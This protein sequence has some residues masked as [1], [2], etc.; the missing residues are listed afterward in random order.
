[1]AAI[2][3]IAG[4]GIEEGVAAE[5]RSRVA[6]AERKQIWLIVWPGVSMHSS[7]TVRPTLITIAGLQPAIDALDLVLGAGMRQ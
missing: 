5:Q 6:G 2:V 3:A 1:M 4:A 7:S